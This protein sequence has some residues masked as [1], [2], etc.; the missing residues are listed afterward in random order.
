MCG[1][2]CYDIAKGF[3]FANCDILLKKF[4]FCGIHS[5]MEELF[6]LYHSDREY[7]ISKF[8]LEHL[9]KLGI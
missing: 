1:V 9:L 2:L 5:R 8:K 3:E 7:K 4:N 6:E